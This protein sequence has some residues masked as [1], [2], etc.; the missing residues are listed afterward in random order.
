MSSKFH[1]SPED[2]DAL[3]RLARRQSSPEEKS[4]LLERMQSDPKLVEQYRV[5]RFLYRIFQKAKTSTG[6]LKESKSSSQVNGSSD[7]F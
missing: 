5:S 4:R 3:D 1:L 2:L 6:Q 7:K